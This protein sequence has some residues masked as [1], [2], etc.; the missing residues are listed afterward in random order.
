M[1][2]RIVSLWRRT[3][4][5]ALPPSIPA[6]PIPPPAPEV[7]E[8][9]SSLHSMTIDQ[10]TELSNGLALKQEAYRERR[11]RISRIISTKLVADGRRT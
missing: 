10:L 3:P 9:E 8:S 11:R 7:E 6:Q 4:E 5:A 2:A 1:F